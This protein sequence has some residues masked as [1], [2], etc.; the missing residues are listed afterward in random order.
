MAVEEA[1]LVGY[2]YDNERNQIKPNRNARLPRLHFLLFIRSIHIHRNRPV[3]VHANAMARIRQRK[4]QP[5]VFDGGV[6]SSEF[7]GVDVELSDVLAADIRHAQLC[8]R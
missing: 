6:F 4:V 5:H 3:P 8:I 2:G 7:H 1:E